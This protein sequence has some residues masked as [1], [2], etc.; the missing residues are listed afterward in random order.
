[1]SASG[2][3]GALERN[4]ITSVIIDE[5]PDNLE[6]PSSEGLIADETPVNTPDTEILS[7]LL[8][9]DDIDINVEVKSNYPI[10]IDINQSNDWKNV[11]EL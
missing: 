7:E 1:M 3:G 6:I 10:Q 8:L 4:A 5:T 11:R 9:I 2:S